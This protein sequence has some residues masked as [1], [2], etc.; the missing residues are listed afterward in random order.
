MARL[1]LFI[2]GT[3][4]HVRPLPAEPPTILKAFQLR[5]FDGTEYDLC[6]TQ[7]GI[8]CDCPDYTFHREGVDPEGC[9]HVKAL[10]ACGLLDP[11]MSRAPARVATTPPQAVAIPPEAAVPAAP[12]VPANGQPTTFLEIVEHEAMGFRAWG[13]PV[14][15]FLASQLDRIAQLIRW[16]GARTPE[17][18]EDRMEVY[19]RELRDRYYDQGYHDG[20]EAGRR[21][22]CECTH[23]RD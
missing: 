17:D 1:S 22:R 10:V 3:A 20:L 16:T 13:T 4:Y 18:H 8:S 11:E 21:E 12:V 14:G 6:Q 7:E 2:N 5:K 9:K 23:D 15:S 19:D